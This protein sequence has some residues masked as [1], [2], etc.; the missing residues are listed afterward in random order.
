MAAHLV[1]SFAAATGKI[2]KLDK[3]PLMVSTNG[4]TIGIHGTE[5]WVGA[6]SGVPHVELIGGS[7]VFV[8]DAGARINMIKP[9]WVSSS[10]TPR[11]NPSSQISGPNG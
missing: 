4:A 11:P 3:L 6:F 9:G 5:F 2:T 1:A 10:R 7:V 8:E